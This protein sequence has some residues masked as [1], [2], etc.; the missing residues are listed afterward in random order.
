MST[1]VSRRFRRKHAVTAFVAPWRTTCLAAIALSLSPACSQQDR[2]AGGDGPGVADAAAS[3]ISHGRKFDKEAAATLSLASPATAHFDSEYARAVACT[4][5][6]RTMNGIV[7]EYRGGLEASELQAL[8]RAEQLYLNDAQ[9]HG[10]A[11]NVSE[12]GVRSAINEAVE[13]G[14]QSAAAQV[15]LSL[16]CLQR[17]G[18]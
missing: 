11:E 17:L 3:R 5:A 10:R 4:S 8:E 14:S 1:R 9:M 15:Q 12:E 7:R 18:T 6:L 16:A 2:A 13:R